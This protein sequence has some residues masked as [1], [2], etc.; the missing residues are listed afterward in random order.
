MSPAPDDNLFVRGSF[1]RGDAPYGDIDV[2]AYNIKGGYHAE[3]L[4]S[5]FEGIPISYG[6]IPLEHL[7]EYFENCI[8]GSSSLME[9]IE[10]TVH[11]LI[12]SRIIQRQQQK[13]LTKRRS[14]YLLFLSL[15]EAVSKQKYEGLES[16]S[17]QDL[18]RK[19]GSKRTISRMIW[20]YKVIYPQLYS[21]PGTQGV[22]EE[23]VNAGIVSQRLQNSV[24]KVLTALKNPGTSLD[25]LNDERARV[26]DW[27][28]GEIL[29][30][31]DQETK[32]LPNVMRV[33]IDVALDK[34][35]NSRD[36]ITAMDFGLE[37]FNGYRQWMILFALSSNS[38]LD[39][40]SLVKILYHVRGN[41]VYRN[42][43]RNL[44]YNP[45][46]PIRALQQADIAEDI[47][48][49]LALKKRLER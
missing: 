31:I 46:F 34:S 24:E 30:L 44:I 43:I 38:K 29:P 23:L 17:Y 3:N 9:T 37:V 20:A 32:D 8:R 13:F 45:S 25:E 47:Y 48:A 19:R 21:V 42:V 1:V 22:M 33:L 28:D 2:S 36:L 35:S 27:F 5:E 12:P 4:S 49:Q 11:D 16:K 6:F 10:L 7:D 26:G 40:E 41:F 14:D 39:K 18:K 15:E